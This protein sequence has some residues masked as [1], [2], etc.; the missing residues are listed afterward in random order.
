M[1]ENPFSELKGWYFDIKFLK[2]ME[3]GCEQNIAI[4]RI[5]GHGR[6]RRYLILENC[7]NGYY[8]HG[9]EMMHDE[10]TIHDGCL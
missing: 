9:F 1:I 2:T 4:F 3:D 10:K 5:V 8:G 7:H 6:R